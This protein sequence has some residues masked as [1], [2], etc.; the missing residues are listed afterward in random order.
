MEY[1]RLLFLIMLFWLTFGVNAESVDGIDLIPDDNEL[2]FYTVRIRLLPYALPENP[3]YNKPVPIVVKFSFKIFAEGKWLVD[4]EDINFPE[5]ILVKEY[6]LALKN[7]ENVKDLEKFYDYETNVIKQKIFEN[8]KKLF[9]SVTRNYSQF[10]DIRLIGSIK[11]GY[12]DLLLTQYLHNSGR[13]QTTSIGGF[14]A[15]NLDDG[16]KITDGPGIT[17]GDMIF[18][19]LFR[20]E[21]RDA[22]IE[23]II[24]EFF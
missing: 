19:N 22:L 8:D 9:D 7:L 17:G 16:Y 5:E 12:Y 11:Y 2:G 1:L 14:I 13:D 4:Q 6:F 18:H 21:I 10:S 24:E 15:I 3:G 23:K 20:T